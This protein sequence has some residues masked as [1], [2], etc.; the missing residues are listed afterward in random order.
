MTRNWSWT[1]APEDVDAL[2]E[3]PPAV[4]D[5]A[6][7]RPSDASGCPVAAAD[8]EPIPQ[9]QRDISLI[10]MAGSMAR[11]GMTEDE[12]FA[13]LSLVDERCEP[14]HGNRN[15]R[16]IARSASRYD[17]MRDYP[18]T[19]TG[20]A[21]LYADMHGRDIRYNRRHDRWYV[22]DGTRWN[23]NREDELTRRAIESARARGIAAMKGE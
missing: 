19:D 15:L 5:L 22:W 2:P 17:P 14:R 21:E 3:A 6:A 1:L 9:G 12:I 13:A 8:A 4:V 23:A 20:N 11:Q 10:K 18:L 16:R 7:V